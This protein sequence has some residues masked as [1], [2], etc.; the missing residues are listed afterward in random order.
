[1]G[2]V[3]HGDSIQ[4]KNG[5]SNSVLAHMQQPEDRE[6]D[7]ICDSKS[8]TK[9]Q[10]LQVSDVRSSEEETRSLSFVTGQVFK[11][12]RYAFFT[13]KDYVKHCIATLAMLLAV[14]TIAC[15]I[16]GIAV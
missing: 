14:V 13:F 8:K 10:T 2:N 1:M 12:L 3:L 5:F 15:A 7:G 16:R 4:D 11:V 9:H 6:K